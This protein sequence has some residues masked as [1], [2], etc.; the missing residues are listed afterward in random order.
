METAPEDNEIFV[1]VGV[2]VS[3]LKV[4]LPPTA[5]PDRALVL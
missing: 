1:V 4:N 3:V 2:L 5:M